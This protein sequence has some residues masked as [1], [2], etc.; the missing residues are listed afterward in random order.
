MSDR[1]L[2]F[3]Y[4]PQTEALSYP[5]ECP[6]KTTRAGLTRR[7]LLSF[8]LLGLPDRFEVAPQ[9]ATRADLE[10]FHT[11]RYLDELQRAAGGQLTTEGLHMG[12]GGMDTPVFPHLFDYGAWACGGALKAAEVLLSGQADVAFNLHGGFHHAF[13]DKAEGFCYLNDVVLACLKL[14]AAGQRVA[15]LDID[16]HHGDGV[17]AAF[18]DRRDVLTV[19]LH[20]TGKTLFPWG[21]F[22]N[23]IGAGPGRGYN[24]NLSLPPDTYD[25]AFLTGFDRVV[26]P[27][28]GAYQPEVLVLE[29][30]MDTLAGDPLTHLHLTNNITAEVVKRLLR[31][32][33]PILVSG[34]GGYHVENTV[35]G[36]A[37]AW[38]T[39]CGEEEHDFSA[40][41]GGCMLASA[42]WIGGLRDPALAVTPE[43]RQA[44]E[45]ELLA[46]LESVAN[47]VFPYHGLGL[48]PAL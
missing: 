47:H 32:R 35:R 5:P 28:L 23:E 15:Y 39:C 2:A 34:G 17:Q 7:K 22:E 31:F 8:G 38:R 43:Q 12:L 41:M 29:L 36:W 24:V 6:F 3:I 9:P 27:L 4:A 14:A 26:L 42:E 10:R 13:A 1:K 20:E 40:G 18:Y 48:L 21:G 16:A 11:P 45:P 30:G 25:A 33:R 46:T 37:S 19:S 44:V